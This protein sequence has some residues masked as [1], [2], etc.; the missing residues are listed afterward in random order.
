MRKYRALTGLVIIHFAIETIEERSQY[1]SAD[2]LWVEY[3][4]KVWEVPGGLN[5]GLREELRAPR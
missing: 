1:K 2:R 3:V 5:I 4:S